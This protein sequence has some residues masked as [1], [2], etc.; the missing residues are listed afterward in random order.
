MRIKA[1]ALV[2]AL[3]A[4]LGSPGVAHAQNTSAL[5]LDVEMT[6]DAASGAPVARGEVGDIIFW[7]R[8]LDCSA[9]ACATLV[10]F[11]NFE[12]GRPVADADYRIINSFNDRQVFGRAY[13]LEGDAM[14]GVDYV[15][16]LDGG[17]S[18]ENVAGNVSRWTDVVAAFLDHFRTGSAES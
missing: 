3:F 14:V 10:F 13:L 7:V 8:G 16:E 12:L 2:A 15:I 17:V 6:E 9:D 1:I 4:G 18:R 11:A 5:G